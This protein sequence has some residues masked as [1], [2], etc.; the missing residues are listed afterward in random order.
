VIASAT[1]G[2]RCQI[3]VYSGFISQVDDSEN[4]LISSHKLL[5]LLSI[6][7]PFISSKNHSN[8]ENEYRLDEFSL[9][10]RSFCR[11]FLVTF[12]Q[13]SVVFLVEFASN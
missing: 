11:L 13:I 9:L 10:F 6:K 8:S 7:N 12:Q 5:H 4:M 1:F 2:E 3:C